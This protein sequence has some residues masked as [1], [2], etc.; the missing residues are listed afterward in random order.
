MAV[1]AVDGKS[2]RFVDDHALLVFVENLFGLKARLLE[3]FA[4]ALGVLDADGLASLDRLLCVRLW[5][6]STATRCFLQSCRRKALRRC[7][8]SQGEGLEQGVVC[9]T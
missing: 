3:A 9:L 4:P 2:R 7:R 5:Q 6:P 1:G 8:D